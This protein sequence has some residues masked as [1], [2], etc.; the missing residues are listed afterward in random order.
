M[1]VAGVSR[2]TT[3]LVLAALCVGCV[4]AR[5]RESSPETATLHAYLA[6]KPPELHRHFAVAL[7]QGQRNRVLNDMRLGLATFAMGR[8]ALAA[9]LFDDAL[10]GIE[11]VYA[12]TEEA[13]SARRLMV[14]EQVKDFKG[15]PYER[16][17]AYY[18][19]GL[20]Y[21]RAGDYENARAS[22]KGG[23]LQ[24]AFAE[25]EQYRADF[26]LMPFLQGWA[27]H[28]WGNDSL[29]AEDFK[30]FRAINAD[31]PLPRDKDN[32]LV[33]VETGSAPVKV[34]DGPRLRIKRSGSTETAR[35]GWADPDHPKDHPQDRAVLLEDLYRQ[36]S[37]RGGRQFDAI[38][39]GKAEYKSAA[40]TVSNV[41]LVGA[42]LA[43][44]V[45][46]E[47]GP[48][49]PHYSRDRNKRQRQYDQDRDVQQG[50]ALVAGGLAVVGLLSKW[51]A[52]SIE[53]DADIRAWDNLSDRI[54]G[55]TLSLPASVTSL[56]VEFQV[57]GG[58]SLGT[59]EVAIQR[60][61]RC[62]LAWVRDGSA[63]PKNPRAPSSVPPEIMASPVVIPPRP[64]GPPAP[65]ITAPPASLAESKESSP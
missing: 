25:E 31:A 1:A 16:V 10:G 48:R 9:E 19:R 54:Q 28:C 8:D 43:A 13:R 3:S 55:L 27:A 51:V 21:L 38:L 44:K 50:A 65:V 62:G 34:S 23:M 11:A 12:D 57:P 63:I 37:T 49:T 45:A 42:V 56:T 52:S 39:E 36:A 58:S 33:L 64:A 15:E 46:T 4:T 35:I 22:F 7:A 18:Y 17:M 14:K 53:A 41:A 29:A 26:A 6:D 24:D 60:A 30:E 47:S 40:D 59:R 20:L 32:V 5:E 61:G 2:L